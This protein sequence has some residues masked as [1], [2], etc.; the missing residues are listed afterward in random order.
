MDSTVVCT[1]MVRHRTGAPHHLTMP[2]TLARWCAAPDAPHRT[3]APA[4][5]G[6]LSGCG[7][8]RAAPLSGSATP[9][10]PA[11]LPRRFS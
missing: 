7:R 11:L 4:A 3:G 9:P 5:G 8:T 2:G 10:C 6:P 1:A